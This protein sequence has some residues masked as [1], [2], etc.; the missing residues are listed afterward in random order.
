MGRIE[1]LVRCQQCLENVSSGADRCPKCGNP[2]FRGLMGRAGTE[3]YLNIG[4]LGLLVLI[5]FALLNVFFYL[6]FGFLFLW[7]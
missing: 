6:Y 2:I 4:C 1:F 3:R 5:A 7:P